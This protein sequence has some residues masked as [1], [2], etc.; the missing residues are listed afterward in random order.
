MNKK[1]ISESYQQFFGGCIDRLKEKGVILEKLSPVRQVVEYYCWI[2]RIGSEEI[3]NEKLEKEAK[4]LL[5]LCGGDPYWALFNLFEITN[6]YEVLGIR[7][8]NLEDA[9]RVEKGEKSKFRK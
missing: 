1:E 7:G 2:K 5:G 4:I 9:I 6:H 8:W 3:N